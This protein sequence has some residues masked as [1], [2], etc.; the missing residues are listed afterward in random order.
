MNLDEPAREIGAY[1][2]ACP[3]C[4]GMGIVPTIDRRGRACPLCREHEDAIVGL[5]MVSVE[6]D[7]LY[8][9]ARKEAFKKPGH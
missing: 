5:G 4:K 9:A 1:W 2:K 6:K 3:L 7:A 8:R